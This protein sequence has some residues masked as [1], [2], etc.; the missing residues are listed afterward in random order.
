LKL[1]SLVLACLAWFFISF[2]AETV[3]KTFVVP[4]EYG[5][6]P[7]N[8]DVEDTAPTEVR[9]TL[10]GYERAFNLLVPSSL[11]VSLDL[12]EVGEGQQ[13]IVIE[14]SH[15]KLPQDL[16]LFRV[17]PRVLQFKV[18]R[19]VSSSMIVEARTQGRLPDRTKLQ[20]ITITPPTVQALIWQSERPRVTKLYTE[21]IDLSR[22]TTSVEVKTKLILPQNVR[23]EAGKVPEAQVRI[24]VVS[25][26]EMP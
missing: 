19:W 14:Q 12:S 25:Q 1:A 5:K 15:M 24:E 26:Q 4:V 20:S 23:F 21:P 22:I 17:L 6:L 7:D 8:M 10:S 18:Y 9:I 16:V 13:Q 3:Q 11:K 2:E